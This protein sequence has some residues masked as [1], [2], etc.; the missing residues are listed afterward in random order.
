MKLNINGA[1]VEV[2]ASNEIPL[3]WVVRDELRLTA[4]KFGC[5][6]ALC[7]ACT[8][9]KD[10]LPIR[11]CVTRADS[12]EGALIVTPEGLTGKVAETLREVWIRTDVVQCGYCQ[13][14]QI[15]AAAAL[16]AEN[17]TPTDTDIDEAMSGNICRCGTY[18]RIRAAIHLAAAEL[19]I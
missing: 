11:S 2:D 14:G 3:L 19:A 12:C 5:G 15:M 4:A 7:G 18:H 1:V 6:A 17:P 16:L 13:P 9:Y 10:G 8:V